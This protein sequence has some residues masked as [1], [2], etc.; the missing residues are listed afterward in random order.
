MNIIESYLLKKKKNIFEYSK[1]ISN[2]ITIKTNDFWNDKSE[3]NRDLKD[4]ASLYIDKNYFQNNSA[5]PI[6]MA[7]FF[8]YYNEENRTLNLN[9]MLLFINNYYKSKGKNTL[10]N[11]LE[12]FY[13]AV[14]LD[15]AVKIDQN[16]NHYKEVI[17]KV[18]KSIKNK[19]ELK[20]SKK[21]DG[22]YENLYQKTK[23]NNKEE[24]TFINAFDFNEFYNLFKKIDN[25]TY[26]VKYKYIIEKSNYKQKIVDKI[27]KQKKLDD[28]YS[29]MSLE[30]LSLTL[31]KT[32]YDYI[33]NVPYNFI[34]KI[35]KI[36]QIFCAAEL[37]KRIKFLI[38]YENSSKE[39][40][41]VKKLIENGYEIICITEEEIWS[42]K[43]K[44]IKENIDKVLSEQGFIKEQ[45]LRKENN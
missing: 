1:I 39:Q 20:I 17:D 30:L 31:L 22:K 26:Y 33:V 24:N 12:I 3:F 29:L 14:L 35:N 19:T 34:N 9:P 11:N 43:V 44:V 28:I 40:E 41:F 38:K 15:S 4:L 21:L 10:N 27:Y 42:D 45:E 16:N 5:D 8:E 6:I 13:L 25:D 18:I 36:N 32:N 2:I 37:K 23:E 7:D